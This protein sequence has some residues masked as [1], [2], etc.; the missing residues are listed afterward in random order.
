MKQ[1]KRDAGGWREHG[2]KKARSRDSKKILNFIA[3]LYLEVK[4]VMLNFTTLPLS[5]HTKK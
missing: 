4:Q 1:S 2:S 3:T 5:D